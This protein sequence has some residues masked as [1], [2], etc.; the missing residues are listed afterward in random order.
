M[1]GWP[2]WSGFSLDGRSSP[3]AFDVHLEDRGMVDQSVD[4][5]QGHG[6]IWKDPTPF[7]KGLICRDQHGPPFVSSTYEFEQHAGLSLIL[8]DVS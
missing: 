7:T 5:S 4:S 8:G 2:S 1:R 3:E 6:L